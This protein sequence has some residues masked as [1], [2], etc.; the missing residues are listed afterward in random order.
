MTTVFQ[1]TIVSGETFPNQKVDLP[2]FEA[3]VRGS[4]ITVAL[5]SITAPVTGP[6]VGNCVVEF[7]ADL[8]TGETT[9]LEG[10]VTAHSGEPLAI[11]TKDEL[12]NPIVGFRNQQADGTGK[13]VLGSRLGKEVI[14]ATHNLCDPTTW[15]SESVRVTSKALT[16]NAGV[17][18]SGDPNWIDMTHGKVFDEEG[19][20]EDQAIFDPGNPHCYV[21]VVTV[22]AVP[23]TERAAFALSGGDY[24]VDY[25]TG[26]VTP[27]LEDWTGKAVLASYSKAGTSEW[28]LT[29]TPGRGLQ[30]EKAEVQFASN[31]DFNG[32]FRMTVYGYAAIF[33]PQLGLPAG[34]RI[35]IESTMY[36][37]IDQIIDEAVEAYPLI[38]AL[39]GARGFTSPRQIFQFHY[40]SARTAWS[41][42]GMQIRVSIDGDQPYG[43]ERA[44]AT[45]Y[46]LSKTDPGIT[47]ALAILTGE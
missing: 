5:E 40:A 33:A 32:S 12:G 26:K 18:E 17:W 34:T 44:T 39:G 35:P 2:R 20:C 15:Y 37:T 27:V 6:N 46:C 47:G 29:P 23:K 28:V 13:L 45:F 7:K 16:D 31:L 14:Y 41:S 11:G 8:S 36:K 22:D 3:E 10:L 42:L 21:V 30:I 4:S 25:A 43:G 9:T 38:P 1:F 24:T 19:I